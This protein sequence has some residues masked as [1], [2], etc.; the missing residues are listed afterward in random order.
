ME[1]GWQFSKVYAQ[2]LDQDGN[3]TP[4]YWRWARN[5]WASRSPVRYP[6]GKGAKPAFLLWEGER[7][8]Y[9]EARKRVYLQLYREAVREQPA[10]RRLAKLAASEEI[11][12]W[13]FDGYDHES[14]G[15]SLADVLDDPDRI[16]GHAFVLKMMLLY[17]PTVTPEKVRARESS[18][19]TLPRPAPAQAALF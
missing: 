13:D 16:C 3:V 14:L 12:L 9:I 15:M 19:R 7:L 18:A 17:G 1:C 10:F 2:H 5:G 8:G 4:A 6:M 11:A